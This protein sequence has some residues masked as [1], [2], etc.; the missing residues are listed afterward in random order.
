MEARGL[1]GTFYLTPRALDGSEKIGI[2]RK[3]SAAGHEI[4]N[5]SYSHRCSSNFGGS[6][7]LEEWSLEQIEQDILKA[8]NMLSAAFP[9]QETWTYAY[10]CYLTDVGRGVHRQSYVPVVARHFLAGRGRG[11]YPFGNH[12]FGVDLACVWAQNVERM[13]GQEMIGIVE[14]QV[15]NGRW[16]VLA[17]HEIDGFRLSV[18]GEDFLCLLDYLV[19]NRDRIWAAPLG[20]VA[21]KIRDYQEHQQVVSAR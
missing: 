7:G 18:S 14:S 8:Q 10:P 16:G 13:S 1:C 19:R 6:G 4:G 11:E 12:P 21:Q 17:F 9:E 15:A 5:H 20:Q 2:W 3:V